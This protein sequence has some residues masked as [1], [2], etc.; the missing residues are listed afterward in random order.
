MF[1]KK[2]IK[3]IILEKISPSKKSK[4]NYSYLFLGTMRCKKET[5]KNFSL[6]DSLNHYIYILLR[7]KKHQL[8]AYSLVL[9]LG[10]ISVSCSDNNSNVST[11]TET[12]VSMPN[13]D[14][15]LKIA[16]LPKDTVQSFWSEVRQGA[17]KAAEA[18]GVE[19][20]WAGT[21]SSSDID[22]QAKLVNYFT[23]ENKVDAIVIA[24]S[25]ERA[26][27]LPI[28]NAVKA[29]IPVVVIDSD[30]R[31]EKISSFVATD[32]IEAG[33]KC[34]KKAAEY[35]EKNDKV[36]MLCHQKGS[37]S[38]EAREEGFKIGMKIF[39][40]E[41]QLIVDEEYAGSTT[42][43]ATEVAIKLLKKYPDVKLVFTSNETT[44]MGM[45]MALRKTKKVGQIKFIGFDQNPELRDAV[46]KEEIQMLAIQNP[47]KIGYS[48]V[49]QAIAVLRGNDYK[50]KE[51]IDTEQLSKK[52][53]T[54]SLIL[55][56]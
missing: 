12:N 7:M 31:S 36:L 42:E 3:I 49:K 29:N 16:V 17:Y 34:A 6:P 1:I 15:K 8:L 50:E 47:Y 39:A 13:S 23:T 51:P 40:P 28:E 52:E 21:G 43:R 4:I 18:E 38:T 20:L 53:V 48:G 46:A 19:V 25:D 41:A 24:P 37:A 54:Q 33:Q 2:I 9:G 45:L 14:R 30:L 56:N 55:T 27:V 11:Q 35:I 5:S 26:L 44:T 32:N 10:S 22:G